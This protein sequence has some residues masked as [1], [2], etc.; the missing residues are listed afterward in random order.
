MKYDKFLKRSLTGAVLIFVTQLACSQE[1]SFTIEGQLREIKNNAT[2]WLGLVEPYELKGMAFKGEVINGKF[3]IEGKTYQPTIATLSLFLLDEQGKALKEFPYTPKLKFF[4]GKGK[5]IVSISD[6]FETIAVKSALRN[7]QKKME[8]LDKRLSVHAKELK[9]LN[10]ALFDAMRSGNTAAYF[11]T[12][13]RIDKVYSLIGPI[14]NDFIKTNKSSYLSVAL[15]MNRMSFFNTTEKEKLY[16]A[17]SPK[18]QK[19][20][21]GQ[22]I[23]R[24]TELAKNPVA[25][26]KG[27]DMKDAELWDTNANKVKLSSY[28]GKWL[29]LDFWASWCGPCRKVHP[30][31]KELYA[32]YGNEKFEFVSISI[33]TDKTKWL[34]AIKEDGLPWPQ[35]LDD[36]DAGKTG[37]YGKAFASYRGDSVPMTFLLTPEGK[38]F[39]INPA[40]E[41]IEKALK[42]VYNTS[43]NVK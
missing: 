6:S 38:I 17:L 42:S 26:L 4:L 8:V 9:D 40:K 19:S 23:S 12:S 32:K 35:F 16:N 18:L 11:N 27:Q 22:E 31:M 28:K 10:V 14:Y 24:Q 29:L 25:K 30:G 2:I 5:T 21:I 13:D 34:T 20:L 43:N 33:D 37:W 15:L 39:D 1:M 41:V 36:V 3:T 7:D